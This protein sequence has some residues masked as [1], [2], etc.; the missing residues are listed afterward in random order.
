MTKQERITTLKASTQ[1]RELEASLRPKTLEEFIGQE[2]LKENLYVFIESAKK[3]N[4]SLDHCLFSGP[5]GCG[6]TTLAHIIANEFRTNIKITSGPALEKTGDLA[7]ILTN[8]QF[9]DVLFIDEIHRLNH[10]VEEALYPVLEEFKFDIVVGQG[11]SAKI[12]RLPIARFTLVGATTRSGLL[13]S[14]FRSRFG[15]VENLGFYTIEELQKIVERSA[16]ILNIE[17]EKDASYEI[18]KRSR[19]TPRI[20]NRL[21]NRVRDFAIVKS[22]GKI[23]KEIVIVTMESLGIDNYGLDEMDRKIIL[24]VIEKFGGGP[25]GIETISVAVHEEVDTVSDVYEPYLIQA[26]FLQ[27]TPRGRIATE[28]AY[29]H[30]NKNYPKLQQEL[31]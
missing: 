23:T 16:K 6:K 26:G 24:T 17:I 8:L 15:I 5:P 13:S 19:G 11:P 2:K 20:S 21:L 14:P 22:D 7:A 28:L 9:Q 18:A 29:K 31:F 1:E 25:V 3:R 27:R 10:I 30:F 12:V 4:V